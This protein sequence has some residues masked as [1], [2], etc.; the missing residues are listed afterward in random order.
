MYWLFGGSFRTV[1]G[2]AIG[3]TIGGVFAALNGMETGGVLLIAMFVGLAG[4][5]VH[6]FLRKRKINRTNA[7]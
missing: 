7:Q 3:A 1:T 4:E 2:F 5:T 6:H